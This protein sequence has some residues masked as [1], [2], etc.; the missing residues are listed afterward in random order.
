MTSEEEG[1]RA[2]KCQAPLD[3]CCLKEGRGFWAEQKLMCPCSVRE[4]SQVRPLVERMWRAQLLLLYV[5]IG[6]K[7]R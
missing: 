5:R 2:W 3:R 1:G 7:Y 6:D 4:V